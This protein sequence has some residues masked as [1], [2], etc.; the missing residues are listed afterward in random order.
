MR[1]G[2]SFSVGTHG[3]RQPIAAEYMDLVCPSL[4][5]YAAQPMDNPNLYYVSVADTSDRIRE[6]T[7]IRSRELHS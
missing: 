6:C 2:I 7:L 4:P 3:G 5:T 1:F